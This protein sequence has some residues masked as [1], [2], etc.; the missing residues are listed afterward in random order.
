MT[1]QI[2]VAVLIVSLH[3]LTLFQ[4]CVHTLRVV[5]CAVQLSCYLHMCTALSTEK[6]LLNLSPVAVP[7]EIIA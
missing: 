4:G 6:T 5:S 3:L 7:T 1:V 2:L